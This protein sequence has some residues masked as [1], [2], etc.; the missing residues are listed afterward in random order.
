MA[1]RAAPAWVPQLL[2]RRLFV[3]TSVS[4]SR[5]FVSRRRSQG[6]NVYLLKLG[7]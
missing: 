1:I 2:A 4:P 5:F 7:L 6:R 3:L